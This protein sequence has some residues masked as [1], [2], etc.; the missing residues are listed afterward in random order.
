MIQMSLSKCVFCIL[1]HSTYM[2]S[3]QMLC[4]SFYCTL[5]RFTH[6]FKTYENKGKRFRFILWQ[7]LRLHQ[8][9]QVSFLS[10][11]CHQKLF[12]KD[13]QTMSLAITKYFDKIQISQFSL[14]N[15]FKLQTKYIKLEI[16]LYVDISF[17]RTRH[18]LIDDEA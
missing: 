18:N 12:L 4:F 11:G 2:T 3:K 5:Y 13:N 17:R 6:L 7:V 14:I 8:I 16:R 9:L 1:F 10:S 15:V